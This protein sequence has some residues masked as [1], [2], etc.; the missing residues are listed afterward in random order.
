MDGGSTLPHFQRDA[1]S[2]RDATCR[3]VVLTVQDQEEEQSA[4]RITPIPCR[5]IRKAT[6]F[7]GV[8]W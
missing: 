1:R 5:R 7:L 6:A 8:E 4:I 3:I 2:Y